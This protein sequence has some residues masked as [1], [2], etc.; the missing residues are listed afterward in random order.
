MCL[1]LELNML[2]FF[3]L[4]FFCVQIQMLYETKKCDNHH[5]FFYFDAFSYES[6]SNISSYN[7]INLSE[8][9]LYKLHWSGD[10]VDC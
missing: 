10:K 6:L 4:T 8:F 9:S 7:F 1:F 3:V 2:T 5:T